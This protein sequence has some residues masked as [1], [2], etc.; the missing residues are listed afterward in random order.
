MRMFLASLPIHEDREV[1]MGVPAVFTGRRFGEA[2]TLYRSRVTGREYLIERTPS[3]RNDYFF[4]VYHNSRCLYAGDSAI[5]AFG[6]IELED[7]L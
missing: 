7:C 6:M 2:G 1:K 5:R 4:R 3:E